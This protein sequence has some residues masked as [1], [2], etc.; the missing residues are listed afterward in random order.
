MPPGPAADL[1]TLLRERLGLSDFRP[2]QEAVC[3]AVTAG[4]DVLLVM[5]TG[6]GKSLCYQLPGLARGGTTL[7]VSPLIALMEDQVHKLRSRGLAAERIHSGRDRLASREVCR[8]YLQGKLDFLFIAPERLR[9]PGF[10]EMLA[11]RQLSLI[12]VDEAHCISNWGHD[13][14]TEYR[15]LGQRLP[16]LRPAPVIAMTATATPLVQDDIARQLALRDEARFIHG[17]RRS[18]IGVEIVE[19]SVG[20]RPRIVREALALRQRRPAI[21]YTPTRKEAE[22]LAE[23]LASIDT[24]A[25][26]HAGLSAGDREAVQRRFLAGEISITVATIAF[27][28]GIDKPDIRTVIHTALPGSVEAYYQEIGRAGR[29][30][31]PSEAYLLFSEG[32]Q[33]TLR[34]F[35]AES[36]ADDSRKAIEH[37]K[38]NQLVQILRSSRCRRE[39]LLDYFGEAKPG[40]CGACDICL[41]T[42]ELRDATDAMRKFLSCVFRTGERFGAAHVIDVLLGNTTEKI[43]QAGH[44]AVSTYGIGREI[45]KTEWRVVADHAAAMGLVERRED[46]YGG[47][48]LTG[49][50]RPVLRGEQRVMM[51]LPAPREK[52]R[53]RGDGAPVRPAADAPVHG[54]LFDA[55]R[56]YRLEIARAAGAAPYTI[57]HDRTLEEI[58]SLKPATLGQLGHCYGV[59]AVKLEK[60]GPAVLEIVKRFGDA[61]ERPPGAAAAPEDGMPVK[62]GLP[63]AP[64]DD[65]ALRRRW[66]EGAGIGVLAAEFGRATGGIEARLVRLGLVPD[67]E[68]ARLRP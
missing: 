1:R 30:G 14:R 35:I 46:L 55:L 36:A 26:Y 29:D 56:R 44:V 49:A 42:A 48:A 23:E 60:Y 12:A 45:S 31:L 61:A 65:T 4:R 52:R 67:R 7:V 13:F 5:P 22:A 54:A 38:L 24:A 34:R 16:A 20:E 37:A 2:Y 51:K 8:S 39:A 21:V 10:P 57:F 6:A 28:M 53:R 40:P 18:N 19:A 32:D 9:V 11:K 41:D 58:A 64:E 33:M 50:A 68:T 63:W 47:L 66:N 43:I 3:R 27:G 17:F 25:A 59:G 62:R 15:M